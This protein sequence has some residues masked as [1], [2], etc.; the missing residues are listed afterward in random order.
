MKQF[1]YSIQNAG[2]LIP[3][4][5]KISVRNF[6]NNEDTVKVFLPDFFFGFCR[7]R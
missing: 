1:S 2:H 5:T 6:G 3:K 7:A 4:K